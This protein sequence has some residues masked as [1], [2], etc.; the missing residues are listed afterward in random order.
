MAKRSGEYAAFDTEEDLVKYVNTWVDPE[1][2]FCFVTVRNWVTATVFYMRDWHDRSGH[3][4]P[5]IHCREEPCHWFK[6][7]SLPILDD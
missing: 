5:W 6:S 2:L 4:S 3:A 1:R 7:E